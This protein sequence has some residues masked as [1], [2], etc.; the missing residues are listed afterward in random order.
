MPYTFQERFNVIVH[1]IPTIRRYI[2]FALE[3]SLNNTRIDQFSF[4]G[5]ME[6]IVYL[7]ERKSLQIHTITL[8]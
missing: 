7:M 5:A 2:T 6:R 8:P 4:V 3:V 1:S